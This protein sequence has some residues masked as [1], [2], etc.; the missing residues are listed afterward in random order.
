MN[1][2]ANMETISGFSFDG[3]QIKIRSV[4]CY[5]EASLGIQLRLA[6]CPQR[7]PHGCAGEGG[8]HGPPVEKD[9]T[10]Q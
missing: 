10:T 7:R 1:V 6:H 8:A 9:C 5:G 2:T 3:Q 4:D